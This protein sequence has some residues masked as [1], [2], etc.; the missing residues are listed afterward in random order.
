MK[1]YSLR[2]IERSHYISEYMLKKKIT[3]GEIH[4]EKRSIS[5][6]NAEVFM[7]V[8]P[9]SELSK[10]SYCRRCKPKQQKGETV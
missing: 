1:Y 10:L 6:W 2:D 5:E 7:Y 8:I 4:A 3:A 9:E